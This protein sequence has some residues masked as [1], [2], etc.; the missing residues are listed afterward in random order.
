MDVTDITSHLNRL[1]GDIDQ[2]EEVLKP[3]IANLNDVASK[4][5]LLDKAK[6]YVLVTYSIENA[7]FCKT[8]CLLLVFCFRYCI[9]LTRRTQS[10]PASPRH[11]RKATPGVYGTCSREAVLPEDQEAGGASGRA[12]TDS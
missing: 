4:L 6:L 5:P 12:N 8:P 3:L 7:L 9:S 11:R 2:L 10:C 1:D